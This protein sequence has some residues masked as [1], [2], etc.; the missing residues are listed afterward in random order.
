MA[1]RN[2]TARS[3]IADLMSN[4]RG[5]TLVELLVVIGMV[6]T[7]VTVLVSTLSPLAQIEKS[8]DSARQQDLQQIRTSLDT[9]YTDAGCFPQV[10]TFGSPFSLSSNLLQTGIPIDPACNPVTYENCYRYQ[11]EDTSACPQWSVLY[12]KLQAPGNE[13]QSDEKV[14][15]PLTEM[16]DCLPTNFTSEGYNACVVSGN[17]N[18]DYIS[19]RPLPTPLIATPTL[20]PTPLP[21]TPSNTPTPYP[22]PD[23]PVAQYKCTSVDPINPRGI[24]N[25]VGTGGDFCGSPGCS[26]NACCSFNCSQ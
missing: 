4:Q 5:V 25:N 8:R 14:F 17:V 10:L 15:C 23:C 19:A 2:Y 24:C 21:P 22:T 16:T 6:V 1:K 3:F 20:T 12:A 11:I 13:S 9:Y 18:C 26:G 7:I